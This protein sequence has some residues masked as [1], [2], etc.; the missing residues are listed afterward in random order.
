ML[1]EISFDD[2]VIESVGLLED[3]EDY[4][5]PTNWPSWCDEFRW[6]PCP[7]DE[8]YQPTEEDLD[9]LARWSAEVEA[10]EREYHDAMEWLDCVEALEDER[11][12]E[13]VL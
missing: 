2:Q 8:P 1:S 12:L 3:P 10:R 4:E 6:V 7:E 5:S 11:R 9:E 13:G